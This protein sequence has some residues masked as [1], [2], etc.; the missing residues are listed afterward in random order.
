V[1]ITDKKPFQH[2]GAPETFGAPYLAVAGAARAHLPPRH[3]ATV[4]EQFVFHNFRTDM[5]TTSEL[6]VNF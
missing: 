2:F 1:K 3:H 6:R 4:A 5:S